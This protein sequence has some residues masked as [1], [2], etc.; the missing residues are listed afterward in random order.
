MSREECKREGQTVGGRGRLAD[1]VLPFFPRPITCVCLFQ[2]NRYNKVD[3]CSIEEVD[4]IARKD[5]S[6]PISCYQQ[7]NLDG[8]LKR[9]WAE[10]ALVRVYV[11]AQGG[12][13]ALSPSLSLSPFSMS[14]VRRPEKNAKEEA[15]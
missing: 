13:P 12:L 7:L 9:L 4:S 3:V 10:M 15:K 6:I 8:L 11:E 5:M 1:C 2:R 14:D